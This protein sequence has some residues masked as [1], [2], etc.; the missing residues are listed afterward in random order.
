MSAAEQSAAD[1]VL[2]L[3]GERTVPG[4]PEENYWF[5]RHEAAYLTLLHHCADARVLE[6]GCGEGYG[7]ALLAESARLVVGLDYD[8]VTA[9]HVA[10]RYP[11][12]CGAILLTFR[13]P[14]AP[15]MWWRT[16]R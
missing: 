2:A 15:W 3:T 4:I 6:A 1:A 5:R 12:S 8:A 16:C 14:A 13:C 11:R 9:A 7:A 10:A